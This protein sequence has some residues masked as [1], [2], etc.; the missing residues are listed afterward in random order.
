MKMENFNKEKCLE[1]LEEKRLIE[2]KFNTSL[3]NYDSKK[4]YELM[5]QLSYVVDYF[6]WKFSFSNY[7]EL[8]TNYKNQLINSETFIDEFFFLFNKDKKRI[9]NFDLNSEIIKTLNFNYKCIGLM[10]FLDNISIQFD[11]FDPEPSN[12]LVY[13]INEEEFEIYFNQI[14]NRIK[15]FK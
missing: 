1:L 9:E 15:S 4:Y 8:F 7:F 3:E 10:R 6:V 12:K 11:L 2:K 13:H 5:D 14:Y